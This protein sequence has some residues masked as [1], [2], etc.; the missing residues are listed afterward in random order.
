[1]ISKIED[2]DIAFALRA[3]SSESKDQQPL[4]LMLKM[5]GSFHYFESKD[6]LKRFLSRN[7]THINTRGI[8]FITDK[9]YDLFWYDCSKK[10]RTMS[11]NAPQY[12]NLIYELNNYIDLFNKINSISRDDTVKPGLDITLKY[13]LSEFQ[14]DFFLNILSFNRKY[15][16]YKG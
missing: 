13:S 15:D 11:P 4:I 5:N 9:I 10:L 3:Y 12:E 8:Q 1:M 6:K 7:L 16:E 2:Y 14:K